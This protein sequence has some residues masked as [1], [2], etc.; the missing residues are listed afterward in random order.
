MRNVIAAFIFLGLLS[1]L[2]QA[3]HCMGDGPVT[4]C[5]AIRYIM[6]LPVNRTTTDQA[7]KTMKELIEF[8]G[9][10]AEFL[11]YFSSQSLD[12]FDL[13]S[14][15]SAF[16]LIFAAQSP[17]ELATATAL[18]EGSDKLS[19]VSPLMKLQILYAISSVPTF[20]A[21][22]SGKYRYQ[23]N[24]DFYSNLW[25]SYREAG[26][27]DR[28]DT[29]KELLSLASKMKIIESK[30]PRAQKFIFA[31]TSG[32]LASSRFS[33]HAMTHML[34]LT[35]Y[36]QWALS[37]SQ[38]DKV[39]ARSPAV[40]GFRMGY[41]NDPLFWSA[42]VVRD[43]GDSL[44]AYEKAKLLVKIVEKDARESIDGKNL[45]SDL[46]SGIYQKAVLD[47]SSPGLREFYRTMYLYAVMNR[48]LVPAKNKVSATVHK[49]ENVTRKALNN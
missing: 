18:I 38:I 47:Q 32:L 33:Q 13:K 19:E 5:F 1:P 22:E 6:D 44:T 3:K 24:L 31:L 27:L 26:Y 17:L 39:L 29:A 36:H 7:K 20:L 48:A 23:P 14:P 4:P 43:S 49:F 21:S 37:Y 16:N 25:G 41:D 8:S 9:N 45:N 15:T 10:R 11:K 42:V 46:Y 2:S 35:A 12:L 40:S 34:M 28:D 30:D